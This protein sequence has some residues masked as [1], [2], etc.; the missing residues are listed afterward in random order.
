MV[1]YTIFA[2]TAVVV[3]GAA[4]YW[5]YIRKAPLSTSLLGLSGP[6]SR[7]SSSQGIGSPTSQKRKRKTVAPKRRVA[8]LQTSG[9]FSGTSGVSGDE[10]EDEGSRIKSQQQLQ[11]ERRGI[12]E[13]KA[14]RSSFPPEFIANCHQLTRSLQES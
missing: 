13:T 12:A 6:H 9:L 11:D 3:A 5:L 1:L 7:E 2:W 8:S 10:S 14:L 4:Y